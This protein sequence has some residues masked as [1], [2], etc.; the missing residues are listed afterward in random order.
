MGEQ[1]DNNMVSTESRK[2][3]TKAHLVEMGFD[4]GLW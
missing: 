3:D 2:S 4:E 1:T